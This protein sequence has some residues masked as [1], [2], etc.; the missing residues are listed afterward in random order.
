MF[1]QGQI[2]Y[3]T[4][5]AAGMDSIWPDLDRPRL[6]HLQRSVPRRHFA[7]CGFALLSQIN[8]ITYA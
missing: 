1:T 5:H 3:M 8:K 6:E 7:V 2:I 4:L